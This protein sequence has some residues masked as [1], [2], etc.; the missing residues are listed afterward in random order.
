MICSYNLNNIRPLF[1]HFEVIIKINFKINYFNE[2]T[3]L[4]SCFAFFNSFFESLCWGTEY[5]IRF[6]GGGNA[7]W[8]GAANKYAVVTKINDFNWY[9]KQTTL[10]SNMITGFGKWWDHDVTASRACLLEKDGWEDSKSC[11]KGKGGLLRMILGGAADVL[12][13]ALSLA[14]TGLGFMLMSNPDASDLLI[15]VLH[16]SK[17]FDPYFG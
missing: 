6:A 14:P 12:D 3:F 2:K 16:S 4:S 10:V 13:V 9:I 11:I 7:Y 15:A 8:T 1:E 5:K 17:L